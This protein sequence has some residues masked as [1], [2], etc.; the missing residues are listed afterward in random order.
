MTTDVLAQM[1]KFTLGVGQLPGLFYLNRSPAAIN[2]KEILKMNSNEKGINSAVNP[3]SG[4]SSLNHLAATQRDIK[5]ARNQMKPPSEDW[6]KLSNIL[7][8]SCGGSSRTRS[9]R[10]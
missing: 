6:S 2:P 3:N 7:R 10:K 4:L 9:L 1:R 8:R 5:D